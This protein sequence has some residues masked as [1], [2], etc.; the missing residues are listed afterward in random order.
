VLLRTQC[1]A[2]CVWY[3]LDAASLLR[4]NVESDRC[5]GFL[6]FVLVVAVATEFSGT[7]CCVA[8]KGQLCMS[9]SAQAHV[10]VMWL[11]QLSCIQHCQIVT[12]KFIVQ[13]TAD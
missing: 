4:F 3:G 1:T 9:S 7:C 2:D 6:M 5:L 12:V 8:S 11:N 10:T 13:L